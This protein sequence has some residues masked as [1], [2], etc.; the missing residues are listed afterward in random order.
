MSFCIVC[1][2][3]EREREPIVRKREKEREK[4][5]SQIEK[6]S[7]FIIWTR[8]GKRHRDGW[9]LFLHV[10]NAFQWSP[11]SPTHTHPFIHTHERV[12]ENGGMMV[13]VVCVL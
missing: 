13:A 11:T 1:I 2:E 5:V 10:K 4:G 12:G 3:K 9:T 8:K 7:L 6:C